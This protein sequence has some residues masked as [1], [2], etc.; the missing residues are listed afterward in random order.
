MLRKLCL[1]SSLVGLSLH[2]SFM[3]PDYVFGIS[4][5]FCGRSDDESVGNLK[6]DLSEAGNK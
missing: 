1:I 6:S 2:N 3:V 4:S 5:R